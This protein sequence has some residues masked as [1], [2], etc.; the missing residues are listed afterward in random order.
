[1]WI[2]ECDGKSTNMGAGRLLKGRLVYFERADHCPDLQDVA[3]RFILMKAR[4]TVL[5]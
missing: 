1:M 4:K 2:D 3:Q 5:R